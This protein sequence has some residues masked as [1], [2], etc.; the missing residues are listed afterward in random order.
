MGLTGKTGNSPTSGNSFVTLTL[1]NSDNINVLIL[2]K[3]G[4]D[5]NFFFEKRLGEINLSSSISSSINLDFHNVCLLDAKI[6]LL[7]LGVSNNTYDRAELS[8]TVKFMFNVLSSI[9]GV[10]GSILG[11]SLFL[12]LEPVL[13]T[14]TLEFLR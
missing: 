4:V 12:T 8:D 7:H 14:T 13:V 6:E 10:L 3:D 2:R 1:G 11:V 5:G 9:S